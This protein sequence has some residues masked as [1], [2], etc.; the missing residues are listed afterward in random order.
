MVRAMI[1]LSRRSLL[2]GSAAALALAGR[3]RPDPGE[4]EKGLRALLD[5]A[6]ADP[7]GALTAL[8]AWDAEAL[9]AGRRFDLLAARSGLAIDVELARRFPF[10]RPGRSPYRVTPT[11]GAWL[12]SDA[13][14]LAIADETQALLADA[15]AGVRLP[16]GMAERTIAA[17]EAAQRRATGPRAVAIGD[18]LVALRRLAIEAPRPGMVALPEGARYY[19]LLLRRTSG[20]DV[21]VD[22]LHRRLLREH[23]AVRAQADR[24][25]AQIGLRGGSIGAR[26]QAL[27]RVARWRYP[28]DDAGRDRAVA[29]MNR[30]L[31]TAALHLPRWFEP[32]PAQVHA[33]RAARMSPAEEAAGKQGYR[34]LPAGDRPGRYVVD[35]REIGRRPAWTLPAVV[36]HELLPGHMVQMPLEVLAAPHPLRLDYAQAFL[37]GWAIYAEGLAAAAG[38]YRGDPHG[39]LGYCHWRLFRL[40]RALAD[41]GIHLHGWS[42]DRV[43]AFW[44]EEMG[45]PAYFAPFASDLD[46]IVVEPATRAAEAASWLAIG[47]LARGRPLVAFHAALLK[48]GR[49]R[50]DMLHSA[51]MD[52]MAPR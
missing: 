49:M 28:D 3:A 23:A 36:H 50:T 37:E 13:S 44:R 39:A 45:E 15:G 24:L 29:D 19:T 52:R 16:R 6:Q 2:V 51:V 5:R 38:L 18:Q 42:S 32:L 9:S 10:G 41:L 25:F 14:A 30:T 48:H 21:D 20:D 11:S 46:R 31:A 47:D 26:Y 22:A 35:L 33:V 17:V 27:W 40:C 43:L 4:E 7:A 1:P 8:S 34:M 12:R